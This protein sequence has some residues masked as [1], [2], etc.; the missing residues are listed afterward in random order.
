MSQVEREAAL[1]MLVEGMK[2]HPSL[3]TKFKRMLTAVMRNHLDDMKLVRGKFKIDITFFSWFIEDMKLKESARP[4]EENQL[5]K[6]FNRLKKFGLVHQ[7]S[8]SFFPKNLT[9]I[10]INPN[11]FSL[12]AG[13]LSQLDK[14]IEAREKVFEKLKNT[15]EILSLLYIYLRLFYIR[16]FSKS[17]LVEIDMRRV[18]FLPTG[19]AIIVLKQQLL[20]GNAE[21]KGMYRLVSL[22]ETASEAFFQ[23]RESQTGVRLFDEK[24][25]EEDVGMFRKIYLPEVNMHLLKHLNKNFYIFHTSPLELTYKAKVIPTVEMTLSEIDAIYPGVVSDE[26]MEVER[27]RIETVFTKSTLAQKN[28]KQKDATEDIEDM[29]YLIELLR[30]KGNQ[31]T[32]D[33][34]RAA[35][36]EIDEYLLYNKSLHSELIYKYILYLLKF[37]YHRK[38]KLSTV[39]NYITSLNK[40]LFRNIE[41]LSN[42]KTHELQAISRRL[43]IM[44]YKGATV[45]FIYNRIRKFFRFHLREHPEF[46]DISLLFY[47]K[48]MVFI[49]EIDKILEDL[50]KEY[51]AKNKVQRMTQKH[52]FKLLQHKVLILLGYYF[53]LRRNEARSRLVGDIYHYDKTF[54]VDV[55][56]EGLKKINL[57]LKTRSSK[58]RVMAVIDNSAHRELF[59]EWLRIRMGLNKRSPFLFLD[60]SDSGTVLNRVID[61]SVFDMINASIRKVTRRYCTYHSLRHSFA[62]YRFADIVKKN[63]QTPYALLELSMQLGHETPDTTLSSYIHAN[64]LEII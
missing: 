35:Q 39:R 18:I 30:T 21:D 10:S 12:M 34:I 25:F 22:D 55:N 56:R 40:H 29:E 58:R 48:S 24:D 19:K 32:Q 2:R 20:Y 27:L 51:I 45:R 36:K 61:E 1:G 43:E 41:D 9:L 64:V 46:A 4:K 11:H 47:P 60:V 3:D 7:R 5:Y 44:N 17:E 8:A 63:G 38:L 31:T 13:D 16:P 23:L 33:A 57:N 49:S 53:G 28:K 52:Q 26:L 15:D 54:Y 6:N 42:I 14:V 62:T 50:E 59:E 37:L